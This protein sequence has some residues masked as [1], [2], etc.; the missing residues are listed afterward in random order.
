MTPQQKSVADRLLNA[1]NQPSGGR[2]QIEN[3]H[4]FMLAVCSLPP[5]EIGSI[6]LR[7]NKTEQ[8][9]ADKLLKQISKNI[10]YRPAIDEYLTF[11]MAANMAA[12]ERGILGS[13]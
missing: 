10:I 5:S 6:K 13:D 12:K 11:M 1:I 7:L 2:V 9:I 8:A 3:Y 4:T